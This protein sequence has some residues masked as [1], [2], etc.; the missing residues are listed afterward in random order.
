MADKFTVFTQKQT[1]N[2]RGQLLVMDKPLVMGIINCT[3]DSFFNG[4][5]FQSPQQ[6]VDRAG[7]MLEEGADILDIG[8]MS[9]RPGAKPIG[10]EEEAGR[11]LPAIEAMIKAFPGAILSLDTYRSEVA[12]PALEAGVSILNDITAG[13]QD[14]E[15]FSLAVSCGA[16]YILMHMQGMPDTMQQNPQYKDVVLEVTDFLIGRMDAARKAGL[17]DVILDPGFGFGKTLEHNYLLL[18]HLEV[19]S[20]LG[21]PVLVGVSRKSMI[22]RLLNIRPV[23]A[24]NGTT[25]L[26][27]LALE[28]GASILRVHDVREAVEAVEIFCYLRDVQNP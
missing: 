3:P 7:Q 18:K 9:S 14:P 10:T 26:H 25:A 12:R 22:N 13:R 8:G 16:P 19:F 27:M 2:C 17:K 6:A 15:M 4:G 21:A 20:T 1:L 11:V 23:E 5:A 28:R 24:L